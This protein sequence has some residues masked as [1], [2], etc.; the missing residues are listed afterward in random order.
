MKIAVVTGASSGIGQAAAI[1]IAER[2]VGVIATYNANP[3]G[4]DKT[5]AT[6][7]SNGGSAVALPLDVGDSATFAAFAQTIAAELDDR[8]GRGSFDH[9]VNNAGFG[10]M[11]MFEETSDELFDQFHRVVLK[12]PYFLTQTLLP[13]LADGGAIVNVT[14]NSALTTGLEPGYSA[15]ATMKGG[16]A[17][18]SQ[19]L[20]A[21]L[22]TRGIR[23]NSVAP[24]PTRTRIAHDAFERFPEVIPPIVERTALGRLGE[25]DDIGKVIATL[26]SDDFGWVTG[27]NI[28]VSG[29][30]NLAGPHDAPEAA[31]AR[32][33]AS[34]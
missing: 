16:L 30:F 10:R 20:A 33:A 31:A 24:G 17:V 14:S 8:W 23:V 25:G 21:E 22:G 11:A 4:A 34:H 3:E 13:L 29:G 2:G 28:E 18:L 6:I 27:Q 32:T 9:L 1:R 26:V 5:V 12:G 19:Y 15:Y 7:E